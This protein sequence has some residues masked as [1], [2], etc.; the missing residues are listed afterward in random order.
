MT[1][2]EIELLL[3]REGLKPNWWANGP[4][5]R[6]AA[7]SHHYDKVLYCAAG[8]ITFVLHPSGE[9]RELLP[10]DRLDLPAGQEHSAAVGP[11]GVTCAE[12]W[13]PVIGE[14]G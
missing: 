2:A 3:R 5:E 8:S 14:Q 4:R 7:H 10:G 1:P 12:G 13:R 9:R 11:A 6:Y